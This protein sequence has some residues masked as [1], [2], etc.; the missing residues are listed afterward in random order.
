MTLVV[1]GMV[2]VDMMLPYAGPKADSYMVS[3]DSA[4]IFC[5]L[6]ELHDPN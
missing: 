3:I 2:S 4:Q 1:N 5:G 6:R